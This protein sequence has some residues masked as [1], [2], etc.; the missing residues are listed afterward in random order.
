MCGGQYPTDSQKAALTTCYIILLECKGPWMLKI[1]S[2]MFLGNIKYFTAQQVLWC[3][4][5]KISVKIWR[6]SPE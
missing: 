3:C 5:E 2:L 4:V 1:N 6:L